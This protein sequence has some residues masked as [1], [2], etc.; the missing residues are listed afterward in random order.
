MPLSP[1]CPTC[2][3]YRL[4]Q[5]CDAFA[6]GI[7]EEISLGAFDHRETWPGDNGITWSPS[8]AEEDL[9]KELRNLPEE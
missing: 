2:T 1:Q 3:H 8:I 6:E 7:P 5:K 9:P 4:D